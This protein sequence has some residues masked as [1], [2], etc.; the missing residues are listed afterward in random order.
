MARFRSWSCRRASVCVGHPARSRPTSRSPSLSAFWVIFFF[1][2]TSW[3]RSIRSSTSSGMAS[4]KVWSRTRPRALT[5]APPASSPLSASRTH[6]AARA[7]RVPITT[8]SADR[9]PRPPQ[10]PQSKPVA[11]SC[12]GANRPAPP[13]AR[14]GRSGGRAAPMRRRRSAAIERVNVSATI[15]FGR[16]SPSRWT[17]RCASTSV[18]PAPG[19]ASMRRH[20]AG[21]QVAARWSS[22]RTRFI[23]ILLPRPPRP[24]L[25]SSRRWHHRR[26]R[27]PLSTVSAW[28][29]TRR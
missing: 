22:S 10:A 19:P 25:R 4:P 17:T 9:R 14:H 1:P 27:L 2:T 13:Q 15:S 24:R 20:G 23:R 12:S 11:P 6:F 28:R 3:A 8:P 29:G 16:C 26:L 5:A 21:W 7:C 18:F